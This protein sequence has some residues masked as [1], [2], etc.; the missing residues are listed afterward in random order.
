MPGVSPEV[1]ADLKEIGKALIIG[2]AIGA[3]LERKQ[4]GGAAL[5]VCGVLL[6]I[7]SWL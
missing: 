3:L 1:R 5:A 7:W 4:R 6:Y 2:G